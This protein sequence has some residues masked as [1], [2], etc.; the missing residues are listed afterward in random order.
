MAL[1]VRAHYAIVHISHFNKSDLGKALENEGNNVG[2]TCTVVHAFF[3]KVKQKI[4]EY[5]GLAR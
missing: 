2:Q 3:S 5:R 4:I 1:E